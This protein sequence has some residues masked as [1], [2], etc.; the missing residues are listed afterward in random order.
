MVK[1]GRL[2]AV[3]GCQCLFGTASWESAYVVVGAVTAIPSITVS[4]QN[5]LSASC[6]VLLVVSVFLECFAFLI[7]KDLTLLYWYFMYHQV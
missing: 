4:R 2:S 6:N 5:Q 7:I 3:S 1:S